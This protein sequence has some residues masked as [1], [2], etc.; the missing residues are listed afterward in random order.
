VRR[1][2]EALV[3]QGV[4]HF[5]LLVEPSLLGYGAEV[6]F[7]MQVPPSSLTD[8][9]GSLT[10]HAALR[11]LIATAGPTNLFGSAVLRTSTDMLDF[12]TEVLG[13]ASDSAA[14]ELQ[15]VL[16]PVKRHWHVL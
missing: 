5:R 12:A 15:L 11:Y 1:R 4:L 14:S 8:V 6:M 10:S 16:R 13:R 3:E 2:I 9:A 7:W